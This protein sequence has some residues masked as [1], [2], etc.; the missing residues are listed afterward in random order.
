MDDLCRTTAPDVYAAGDV[1][2]H[3]HPLFGRVRV[4]HW[5]HARLHGAAAARSMMGKGRPYDEVHWFWSNQ[6][7][8]NLQYLGQAG[9]WDDIVIRG[10]TEE[11]SFLAFYLTQGRI[12]AVM[13]F[14]RGNE[15][16]DAKPLVGAAAP[17]DAD[18]LRDPEASISSL[19]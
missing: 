10:S 8:H 3:L 9:G 13:G 14:D 6:Y 18:R 11:R 5:Q 12:V 16:M 19:A 2:L 4:E 1:A 7:E 17:V 15:V